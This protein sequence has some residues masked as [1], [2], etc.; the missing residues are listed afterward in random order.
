MC[1]KHFFVIQKS[2]YNGISNEIYPKGREVWW[3][4]LTGSPK[5]RGQLD[6][7]H[8]VSCLKRVVA[9]VRSSR[10]VAIESYCWCGFSG[11]SETR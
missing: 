4:W 7:Q 6:I 9:D 11:R 3:A 5:L 2:D 10:H 1:M 8:H